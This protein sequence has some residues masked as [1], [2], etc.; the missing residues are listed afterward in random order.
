[1][2]QNNCIYNRVAMYLRKSRQDIELE[3]NGAEDTLSR[4][5]RRLLDV[6]Q[7]MNLTILRIYEEVVSGD[8]IAGRPQMQQLLKDVEAGMYDAVLCHDIDRLGRGGMRDQGTILD[9]FKWAGVAI[10]TPDKIWDLSFELDEEGL[11]FRTLGARFEYRM[12]RKRMN[13]GRQQ[14]IQSGLFIGHIP[15]YGY[16]RVKRQGAKGWILSPIEPEATV[17][18]DIYRWFLGE[19]CVAIGTA[20]IARR[21]NERGVQSPGKGNDWTPCAVRRILSNQ[22]YCGYIC[23]GLRK[24]VKTIKDGVVTVS[25]PRRAPELYKGL[26]EPIV[27]EEQSKMAIAKLS[28]NKSRPGPKNVVMTNPLSGLVYCH[29]CKRSMIRR[30]YSNGRPPS[31]MCAYTSCPCVSSDFATVEAAILEG[32]SEWLKDF[33][34]NFEV[35]QENNV[36][37]IN[38]LESAVAAANAEL[39][40]LDRQKQRTYTLV[41]Q[42]VYTTDV[43]TERMQALSEEIN[44]TK[45]RISDLQKE[46]NTARTVLEHKRQLIPNVKHV[47]SAYEHCQTAKEKNDLLKAVLDHVEYFKS[48]RERWG[49]GSDLKI[50]LFPAFPGKKP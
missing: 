12:I 35:T 31:I 42:G 7:R 44:S 25:R 22:E 23:S 28:K 40:K 1:M 27:T 32:L 2:E 20:L 39:D 38:S 43:F 33:E 24:G 3:N 6:A 11:E 48:N 30:P 16:E 8:T 5:R 17:V 14:S 41:E 37:E 36:A 46:L 47:L 34:N 45:A 19:G 4:H 18:R 29:F 49:N 21:L 10:I 26:H 50:T 15:P 13:Q 9:T